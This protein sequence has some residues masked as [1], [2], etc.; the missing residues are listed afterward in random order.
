LPWYGRA[1]TCAL[2]PFTSYPPGGVANA[3]R[4]GTALVLRSGQVL[5]TELAAVA[6]EGE[7]VKRIKHDGTVEQ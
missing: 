2:E 5:E 3:L 7:G 1:Y 6:Y 4:N